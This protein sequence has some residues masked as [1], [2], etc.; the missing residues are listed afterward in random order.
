MAI[1]SWVIAICI[2]L[3]I[4]SLSFGLG[5]SMK[6]N[7]KSPKNIIPFE[8]PLVWTEPVLGPNRFK[9]VCQLYEFESSIIKI[10]G[11]DTVVQGTPTL[12]KNI[13]D[14]QQGNTDLPICIDTDRII[15]RQVQHTCQ[16]PKGVVG[17]FTTCKLIDGGTTGLGGVEVYYTTAGCSKVSLC[18]GQLSTVSVNYQVPHS[19]PVCLSKKDDSTELEMKRCD[20][21]DRDQLIRV[22]RT[23]PGQNPN[24]LKPGGGQN[25]ILVQMLHRETGLCV[26]RGNFTSTTRLVDGYIEG[27]SFSSNSITKTG[28]GLSSCTGGQYP[29]YVWLFLPSFVYCD[30]PEGCKN[31]GS[32]VTPPQI[33]YIGDLDPDDIP[34]NKSFDGLTG[35]SALLRFLIG[36]GSKS[37]LCGGIEDS[38][39]SNG[40]ILDSIFKDIS[41]CNDK[42][43]I[44]Q[45]INTQLFNT[46]GKLEVCTDKPTS[47]SCIDF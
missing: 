27:C 45:Y 44:C 5:F 10:N 19:K 12:D 16:I 14:F 17:E 43:T 4:L 21:S 20:P 36:K 24:N 8:S 34:Y 39:V 26:D 41:N 31:G 18:T 40:V 15:A 13:L 35:L 23:N 2:L 46:I 42:L 38:S 47:S 3:L 29:G 22:T 30:K 7:P 6:N 11:F 28:I 37:M 32:T 25:G 1:A 9:N 33:I